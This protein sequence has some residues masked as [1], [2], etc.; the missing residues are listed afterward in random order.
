MVQLYDVDVTA[1]ALV[2]HGAAGHIELKKGTEE[3]A[4]LSKAQK[5]LE[6]K[7]LMKSADAV[8]I[9]EAT[10]E[11]GFEA[12]TY[13]AGDGQ[14]A[15]LIDKA[16]E[17]GADYAALRKELSKG[18]WEAQRQDVLKGRNSHV[19]GKHAEAAVEK[20]EL[21]KAQAE[22]PTAG[23]LLMQKAAELI[24]KG[25]GSLDL[26]DAIIK[27]RAENPELAAAHRAEILSR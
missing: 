17:A 23:N 19:A 14:T 3:V 6:F 13:V 4:T 16:I 5:T 18:V 20:A 27:A 9:L 26:A 25:K 12:G 15:G 21:A 7:R 10:I 24:V 22:A 1:L 11:A 2:E 8:D